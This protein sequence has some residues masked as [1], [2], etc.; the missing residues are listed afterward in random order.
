MTLPEREP[1]G[2]RDLNQRKIT[3]N[4]FQRKRERGL[5]F[6]CDEKYSPSHRCKNKEVR[7]LRVLLVNGA[8]E[9][10]LVQGSVSE[11][12]I[13]EDTP[14]VGEVAKLEVGEV[15]ELDLKSMIGFSTPGT[16]K[17]MGKIKER[18]VLLLIDFGA[19]H[20]FISEHFVQELELPVINTN[21]YGIVLGNGVA[22]RGRGVCKSIVLTIP[23]LTITEDFL[24]LQLNGVEVIL[25]MQ[26]LRTMG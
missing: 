22:T 10:E 24:P 12:E 7:E 16:M 21:N 8:E 25:G 11:E 6:K 2:K 4:E 9:I 17:L 20:N 13:E 14:E 26:W 5:C 15:V 3:D 1:L 23:E 19:T 18:D